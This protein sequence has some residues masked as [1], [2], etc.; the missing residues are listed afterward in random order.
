MFPR[1]D[2]QARLLRIAEELAPRF[3]ERA[4]AHDRDATFPHEN[5]Q[6]LRA[7]EYLAAPVPEE[8]GGPGH[9]LTD[10]VLGQLALAAGDGSTALA[11]G[12]HLMVVGTEAAARGWPEE[13]RGRVFRAVVDEGALV[14]NIAAEPELGS[15]RGGGRPQTVLEPA[16]EGAWRLTGHKTFSTLSPA[17][18]F[19]VVYA[20][21][22]DGSGDVA[23][24]LV[25][26]TDPGVRIDETW[27]AIGMRA[28]GSHDVY[29]EG[30][31]VTDAD[32][33]SRRGPGA[34]P[35]QP[36]GS[37]AAGQGGAWFPLLVAAANLGIAEAARDYAVDFARHRKPL[38]YPEPIAAIPHVREQVARMQAA[39]LAARALLLTTAE[40]WDEHPEAR[41]DLG[42]AVAAAKRLATNTAVEM[43]EIA[44][45]IVGGVALHRS[46]PLER[47]FRDVRGGLVNPPIEARALEQI[48]ASLLDA[49][50]DRPNG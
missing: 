7:A 14:N 29:F 48:A 9:G 12:M 4:A 42:A 47:Y 37:S 25:D 17:L 43:V 30:V 31:E 33:L 44:M 22:E 50:E 1:T 38:G 41:A 46:E 8:Y 26:C 24:V 34:P 28:T 18:A 13:L 36:P 6:E 21:V 45:R 40:D 49:G 3:A 35:S 23:R 2:A 20:A 19:A 39:D 11:V 15:P 32:F 5:I 27:D 16:G 10:V